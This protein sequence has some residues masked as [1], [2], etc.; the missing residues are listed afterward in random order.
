VADYDNNRVLVYPPTTTPGIYGPVN[1]STLTGSSAPFWWAGYPGATAY[2]LDI[3]SN[4][5]GN[6]Y[7]QSGPLPGSQ[8]SLTANSLPE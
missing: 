4:Y 6:N 5:G 7:L 8:Y 3:G 2:W 1:G